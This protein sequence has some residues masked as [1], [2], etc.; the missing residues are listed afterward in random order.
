MSRANYKGAKGEMNSQ[1]SYENL[2]KKK[3]EELKIIKA[4]LV[5]HSY[6]LSTCVLNS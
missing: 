5:T 3:I 4:C 1:K 6:Y 2:W